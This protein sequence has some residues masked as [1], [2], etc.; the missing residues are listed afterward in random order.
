MAS[1][2]QT[3]MNLGIPVIKLNGHQDDLI[4][5]GINTGVRVEVEAE[6]L[7]AMQ[8]LPEEQF[9][10]HVKLAVFLNQ[11]LQAHVSPPEPPSPDQRVNVVSGP[12]KVIRINIGKKPDNYIGSPQESVGQRMNRIVIFLTAAIFLTKFS[13]G[14]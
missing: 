14:E 13:V 7:E 9:P 12:S 11:T 10:P 5:L 3:V 4:N 6:T 1:H 8:A 2:K